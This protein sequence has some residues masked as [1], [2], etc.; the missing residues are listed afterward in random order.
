[1]GLEGLPA[2]FITL[3]T[4]GL[5][6]LFG[7]LAWTSVSRE[8]I[9]LARRK[10]PAALHAFTASVG[11]ELMGLIFL[12]TIPNDATDHEIF[13]T[14]LVSFIWCCFLI[15]GFVLLLLSMVLVRV[16]GG[17][18]DGFVKAGSTALFVIAVLGFIW[19]ISG[20]H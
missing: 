8:R 5:G 13:G 3:F 12:W 16:N 9:T 7:L 20:C 15:A 4:I 18:R 2:M 17:D 6:G 1:M 14:N 11:V 19:F 10:I